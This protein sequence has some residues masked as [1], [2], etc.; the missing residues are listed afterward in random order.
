MS[1]ETANPQ[2][3]MK[4]QSR[5]ARA[6]KLMTAAAIVLALGVGQNRG[7]PSAA[8]AATAPAPALPAVPANGE[9][10][11][12][13]V[14]FHT[15]T[16][17][18]DPKLDCPNGL[19]G[20]LKDNYLATLPEA[21]RKRLTLKENEAELQKA[22]QAYGSN[23]GPN[24]TNICA[25]I[26]EFLDRPPTP[27]NKGKIAWGLNLDDNAGEGGNDS[28]TCKHDNF[29][30]PTGEQ[31]VDHQLWR[32]RGCSE[33]Y[34]GIDESGNGE[35]RTGADDLMMS[36]Q[37]TQV[38]LLRGVNSLVN[39]P[40]VQVIY[41]NTED[42]PVTDS[43]GKPIFKASYSVATNGRK[44]EFR[45]ILRG[46]IVNGVLTTDPKDILLLGSGSDYDLARGRLRLMFQPDGTVKGLVGGYQPL[47]SIL[48][49]ARGGGA[50]SV[51][52]G[53]YNCAGQYAA[54]RL[55]ADG[56]KDPKTGQC[57]RISYAFEVLGIPAFVNDAS[58]RNQTASQRRP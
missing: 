45:N 33:L 51:N 16:F 46:R 17:I 38:V 44:A 27:M 53:G 55:M 1:R 50:G 28:Y 54:L 8:T 21:D 26:Y 52:T 13:I 37:L 48:G 47:L 32:V 7:T 15:A 25:N 42:R 43:G 20:V 6:A 5:R 18:A 2:T 49:S 36:G 56:D 11:F 41:A 23:I 4:P 35:H 19:M 31:G 39:D 40:D 3:E 9:M 34:R 30:S 14:Q 12:V 57:R 29:T 24:R 58:A 22:W 10:G